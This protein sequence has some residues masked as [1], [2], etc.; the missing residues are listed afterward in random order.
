[1]ANKT[2][3]VKIISYVGE[4]Y[5]DFDR[6]VVQDVT[7]WEEVSEEDY[8]MLAEWI[9][10]K[11]RETHYERYLLFRKE[12]YE[13]KT[14]IKE[15]LITIKAEQAKKEEKRRAREA[16]RQREMARKNQLKED[17]ERALFEKL[18]A[19]FKDKAQ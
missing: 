9:Q 3:R 13:F 7:G 2:Y 5:D 14:C 6:W 16:K 18:R 8:K 4:Y 19:K 10:I 11:N 12:N 17:E 1:M 15:Y